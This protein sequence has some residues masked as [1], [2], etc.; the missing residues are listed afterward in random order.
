MCLALL[1]AHAHVSQPHMRRN[2]HTHKHHEC[3]GRQTATCRRQLNCVNEC[4]QAFARGGTAGTRGCAN[5]VYKTL[6]IKL[7]SACGFRVKRP[8]S[9]LLLPAVTLCN[10]R[11]LLPLSGPCSLSVE[12][13]PAS[14]LCK[15]SSPRGC[16]LISH[17]GFFSQKEAGGVSPHH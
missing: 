15:S 7:R 12:D 17:S 6:Y 4:M 11:Q 1:H 8:G 10:L 2:A 9:S 5:C 14:A 13:L 3:V 16:L